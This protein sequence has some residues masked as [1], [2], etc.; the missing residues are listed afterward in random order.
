MGLALSPRGQ[1]WPTA[2]LQRLQ[3]FAAFRLFR[4]S[5]ENHDET[6]TYG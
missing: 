5:T 4:L 6:I 2:G 1:N 3:N